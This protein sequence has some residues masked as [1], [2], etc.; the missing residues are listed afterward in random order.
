MNIKAHSAEAWTALN[1]GLPVSIRLEHTG[2]NRANRSGYSH[3]F[4]IVGRGAD[5]Q[6]FVHWG[7]LGTRGSSQTVNKWEAYNRMGA[8]LDKGYLDA[9]AAGSFRQRVEIIVGT[10]RRRDGTT[11][12]TYRVRDGRG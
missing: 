1:S 11:V 4:Y 10:L 2:R 9:S 8:K 5:G 6:C 7:R 12:Q 3:K